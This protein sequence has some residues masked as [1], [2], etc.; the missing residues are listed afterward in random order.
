MK[1]VVLEPGKAPYI[2]DS[3][4]SI[5]EIQATVDGYVECLR[6]PGMAVALFDEEGIMKQKRPGHVVTDIHGNNRHIVGTAI[7]LG[8]EAY[9]SEFS[10]VPEEVIKRYGAVEQENGG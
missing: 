6:I 3:A 10:D 8:A 1:A 9:A 5:S 4:W 7:L 2:K